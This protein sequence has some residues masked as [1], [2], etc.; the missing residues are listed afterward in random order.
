MTTNAT[1]QAKLEPARPSFAKEFI[2]RFTP[3]LIL[4]GLSVI[5]TIL[6]PDFLTA[7]N[8]INVVL[9]GSILAIVAIGQTYVMLTSGID[10][11][12][13]SLVALGGALAAG[14]AV[15]AGLGTYPAILVTLLV[16]A[17]L[18]GVSGLLVVKGNIPPFVS[19]LS[20]MAIARSLMLVYTQGK[21]IAGLGEDFTF[22]G[23]G[24]V[25]GI[26]M[27]VVVMVVVASGAA[28]LLNQTRFGLYTRAVGGGEETLRLAGVKTGNVKLAVY[29]ISGILATLGGILL[30]ARLWSAQPSAGTGMELDA[31]AASVLGGTSLMGGVGSVGGAIIGALTIGV[32]SNGMNLLEVPSY[33]QQV[34]K[35]LVFVL[36]VLLDFATKGR[37]KND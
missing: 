20:M 26:P 32:L 33:Y 35:G 21:P 5:L 27:P 29:V 1:P 28:L 31:I 9:Q 3:V 11:S 14:L 25:L 10:L 37:P 18:G 22:W 2:R 7:S 36:A 4:L 6:N 12:V 19:T 13:G 15:K 16:G 34:V 23:T 30:T 24:V 17:L 8:L